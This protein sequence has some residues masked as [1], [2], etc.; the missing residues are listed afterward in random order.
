MAK[1]III[2]QDGEQEFQITGSMVSH[3]H[4]QVTID[5]NGTWTLKDLNSTNG[6]YIRDANGAFIRV[7]EIAITPDTFIC[8]GPDNSQGCMFYACHLLNDKDDYHHEFKLLSNY[9]KKYTAEFNK[10]EKQSVY[11]MKGIAVISLLL[12]LITLFMPVGWLSMN[13]LR[14]G[15]ALSTLYS[16]FA[17]PKKTLMRINEKAKGF[18]RCPNPGCSY[19]LTASDIENCQCPR[20]RAHA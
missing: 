14:V 20:C 17:N 11:I 15:T 19:K 3:V 6:T 12:L 4:A 9:A 16:L 13:L 8:L 18:Y 7:D 10:A 2:G 5:D 1:T